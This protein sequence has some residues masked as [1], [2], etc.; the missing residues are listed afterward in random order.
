MHI[1]LVVKLP[2]CGG[3]TLEG[4]KSFIFFRLLLV[5]VII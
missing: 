4:K 1:K 5:S 3:R 2:K